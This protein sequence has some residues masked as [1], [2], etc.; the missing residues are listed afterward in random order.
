MAL[1]GKEKEVRS[2]KKYVGLF[3]AHVVAV[4]PTKEELGT[5]L[6]TTIEKDPE[7]VGS[8]QETGAKRLTVSFWLKEENTG[9]HFNVRFNIE[10]TVV[11]K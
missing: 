10:D 9:N 2:Y 8:N 3:N 6:G 1:K 7:Y 11:E 5:L 4:N